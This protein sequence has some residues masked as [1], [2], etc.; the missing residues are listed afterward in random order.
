MKQIIGYLLL[1]KHTNDLLHYK[2]AILTY[3]TD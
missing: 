1:K 2:K 3:E